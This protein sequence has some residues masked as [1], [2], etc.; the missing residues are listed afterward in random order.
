[1][2]DDALFV[3]RLSEER[4]HRDDEDRPVREGRTPAEHLR[5]DDIEWKPC[6]YAGSRLDKRMNVSALRQMSAHWDEMLAALG[7]LRAAYT[8]ARGGYEHN[9]MD[10]WRVSQL[11][12]ALPWYFIL[13]GRAC[14]AYAAALSKATLGVGIWGAQLLVDTRSGWRPPARFT[15]QHMLELAERTGT[16]LARDEVC[17]G[18]DK[19]LLKFFDVLTEDA[20][21]SEHALRDEHDRVMLFGAHYLGLKQMLWVF[22]L[23]R[24][25]LL[26]DCRA[27]LG[28]RADVGALLAAPCEPLDLYALEPP[29]PAAV[30]LPMRAMWFLSVVDMM[31]PIAPD[32]SDRGIRDI[33]CHMADAMGESVVTDTVAR[34]A[35]IFA[36]LDRLFGEAL[37]IAE[38]GLRRATNVPAATRAF[39]AASRDRA[40]VTPARSFFASL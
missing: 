6:P 1:M 28:D 4:F 26:A 8:D 9:L 40:Q 22:C 17:A 35:A 7:F 25:F 24:R 36:T 10:I 19:M 27:V 15:S 38:A 2:S 23:M 14:P 33:A 31:I 11:G 32:G 16:L 29:A 34:A 37:D 30:P 18:P 13:H 20:F 39:D 21:P 5:A 3:L 12:S